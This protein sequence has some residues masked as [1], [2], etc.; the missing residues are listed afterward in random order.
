M[1]TIGRVCSL[2]LVGVLCCYAF[3]LHA[4]DEKPLAE[5]DL[6]SLVH[7]QIDDAV[8]VA[9][10]K[11]GGLAFEPDDAALDR[12]KKNGAS[13][14]VLQAVRAAASPKQRTAPGQALTYQDVLKLLSLGI[15]EEAILKRLEKSPTVF[16]PSAEQI[17]DLK[18]AGAS[19][20]LLAAPQ[21]QRTIS[22]SAKG[23]ITDFAIVLDCS[24]SMKE[25]TKEGETKM[26]VAQRVVTDL[27]QQMPDGLNVTMVIY[28]H[29]AFGG[30]DDP[31]NCQ[32]VKVIRPLS[33]LD[34]TGKSEL[35]RVIAELKPTGATPIALRCATPA[36]NSPKTRTPSAVWC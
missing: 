24:G 36:W 28:G 26:A 27:I 11:Q 10:I 20:K 31:R 35:S 3:A 19:E 6:V 21:E 32:A 5:K 25:L 17:V 18:Q 29:E 12:L 33:K 15:D 14:A 7:L 30:A 16:T 2:S 1:L 9:K 22:P 8:I 13:D 34:E 4:A 23:L